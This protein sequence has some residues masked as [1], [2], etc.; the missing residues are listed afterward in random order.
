MVDDPG[1]AMEKKWL[2]NCAKLALLITGARKARRLT[3][4]HLACCFS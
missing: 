4:T 3:C 1:Q 2:I